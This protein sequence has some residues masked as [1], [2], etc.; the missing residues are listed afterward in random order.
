MKYCTK[1]KVNV[2]HQLDNCPLCGSYLDSANDNDNCA[3][4]VEQ[5]KKI[6][7]PSLK[8]NTYVPFFKQKFNKILLVVAA[9]SI[10]LNLLLTPTNLWCVYVCLAVF[11]AIFGVMSPI[12]N[13]LKFV[14]TLR[15][16]VF[17]ATLSAVVLEFVICNW[18]FKWFTTEYVLPFIYEGCIVALDLLI[19]FFRRTNKQL[20]STLTYVTFYAICPQI[21]YWISP[22]WG[23]KSTTLIPFVSFFAALFNLLIV[24]IVC[25]RS[26]KEEME[27]N[28][29]L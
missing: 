13:K 27:R 19:I 12:N 7:Y 17:L 21:L 25:S 2:N 14:T 8:L 10:A 24:F 11:V 23:V 6:L 22:L 15:R 16:N 3:V 5:D 26:L 20:F 1:C 18:Q 29:S 4:Y 9:C 28:L